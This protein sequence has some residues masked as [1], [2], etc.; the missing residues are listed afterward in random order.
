MHGC[1]LENCLNHARIRKVE[2]RHFVIVHP[3]LLTV[4]LIRYGRFPCLEEKDRS[5]VITWVGIRPKEEVEWEENTPFP[6]TFFCP[7]SH[8]RVLV[9][10]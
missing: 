9:A 2:K 8:G 7:H 5:F 6:T 1:K 4:C 3:R 10:M